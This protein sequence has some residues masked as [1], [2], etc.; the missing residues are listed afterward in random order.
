MDAGELVAAVGAALEVVRDGGGLVGGEELHGVEDE[1]FGLG[2]ARAA[3]AG[4][5]MGC[6]WRA[7]LAGLMAERPFSA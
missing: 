4:K 3:G 1:V 2:V 6:G 5:A 7:G